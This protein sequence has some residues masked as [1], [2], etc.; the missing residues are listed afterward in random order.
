MGGL[1]Q[2]DLNTINRIA[3]SLNNPLPV[4]YAGLFQELRS[5]EKI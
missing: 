5:D 3:A 4:T 1:V 2:G